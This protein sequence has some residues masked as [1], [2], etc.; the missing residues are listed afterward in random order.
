MGFTFELRITLTDQKNYFASQKKVLERVQ[1]KVLSIV[2]PIAEAFDGSF[3]H[4]IYPDKRTEDHEAGGKN[5]AVLVVKIQYPKG[6]LTEAIHL[7]SIFQSLA[8]LWNMTA[9]ARCDFRLIG[10]S[11]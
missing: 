2:S 1:P 7:H 3:S 8:H 6:Q 4:E 5:H 9:D 10:S 11:A